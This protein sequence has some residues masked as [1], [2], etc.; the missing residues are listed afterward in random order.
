MKLVKAG[1]PDQGAV[2]AQ[3]GSYSSPKCFSAVML[4]CKPF[5]PLAD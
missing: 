5:K 1:G 2:L 4:K 3:L